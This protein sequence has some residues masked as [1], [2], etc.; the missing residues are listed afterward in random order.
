MLLGD[1]SLSKPLKGVNYHLSV[2]HSEAQ[3]QYL[4]L[5]YKLLLPYSRPIQ[6][7]SYLDKRSNKYY[8][9]A[10]FHTISLPFFT[11]VR[12][13]LYDN[14]RKTITA[15]YLNRI[16]HPIA[17]ALLIGDD[18]SAVNLGKGRACGLHIATKQ[19]TV[20]ENQLIAFWLHATFGLSTAHTLKGRYPHI[21]IGVK[22]IPKLR[23]LVMR[24]LS[25]SMFYKVGGAVWQPSTRWVGK[26]VI[27]CEY[28]GAIMSVY[29]S[30]HQRFC[31]P[32]CASKG[33]GH[34]PPWY[35]PQGTPPHQISCDCE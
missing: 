16:K 2:Y 7:C 29:A 28:C 15:N 21:A 13:A 3:R 18:G 34:L 11:K 24:Y 4:E 31:S 19:F 12:A 14:K 35:H 17:L 30:S 8:T 27:P 9:G 26:I 10:R 5:K 6:D 22:D 33:L 23:S 1:G 32:S 25:P 20:A